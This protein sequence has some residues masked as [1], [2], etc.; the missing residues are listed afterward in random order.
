MIKLIKNDSSAEMTGILYEKIEEAI[1]TNES[2]FI[3]L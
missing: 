1:I 2:K 3:N